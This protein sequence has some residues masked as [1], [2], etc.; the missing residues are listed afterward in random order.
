MA[1]GRGARGKSKT[2]SRYKACKLRH[3]ESILS[4][5]AARSAAR[6]VSSNHCFAHLQEARCKSFGADALRC[7][8]GSLQKEMQFV[9]QHFWITQAGLLAQPHESSALRPLVFLHYAPAR[10]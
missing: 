10:T 6:R 7:D 1:R 8:A 4:S 3:Q 2:A 5:G 9:G